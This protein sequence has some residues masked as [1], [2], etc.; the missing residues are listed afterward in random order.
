MSSRL[1]TVFKELQD[2]ID[3]EKSREKER[4]ELFTAISH[5]LKTPLTILRGVSRKRV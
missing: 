3:K 4:T 1:N 5:E 2:N